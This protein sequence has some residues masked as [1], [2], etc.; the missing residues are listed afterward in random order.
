MKRRGM[1]AVDADE[2]LATFVD[3]GGRESQYDS[4][5]GSRWWG[6]HSYVLRPGKLE[7][8]LEESDSIFVFGDVGGR[9]GNGDGLL[10]KAHLF[11]RVCFLDAPD[12]VI[13]DRLASRDDNPFGKN[14]EEVEVTLGRNR[15]MREMARSRK[16]Q[17][18]DATLSAE[19]I[20]KAIVGTGDS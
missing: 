3:E 15:E 18:V 12:R 7:G 9:P 10:D 17:M 1:N 20:I 11:D 13:R 6:S 4:A 16:F 19:E 2:S 8:L 5:G 14:P